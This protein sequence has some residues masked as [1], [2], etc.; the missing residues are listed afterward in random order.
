MLLLLHLM[1][2]LLQSLLQRLLEHRQ[3]LYVPHQKM[4]LVLQDL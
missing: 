2:L 4:M 3:N 1:L